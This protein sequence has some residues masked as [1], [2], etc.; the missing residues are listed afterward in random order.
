MSILGGFIHQPL[1]IAVGFPM[2]P[3][4]HSEEGRVMSCHFNIQTQTALLGLEYDRIQV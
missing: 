3:D 2:K 1:L 4:T